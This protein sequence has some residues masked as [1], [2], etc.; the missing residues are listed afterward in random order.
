MASVAFSR[1]GGNDDDTEQE[2]ETTGATVRR[3]RASEGLLVRGDHARREVPR[4]RGRFPPGNDPP[5]VPPRHGRHEVLPGAHDLLGE[6]E[7]DYRGACPPPPPQ[8]WFDLHRR[9]TAPH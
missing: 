5:G 4:R 8:S 3:W 9:R 6:P 2:A 1:F 7:G